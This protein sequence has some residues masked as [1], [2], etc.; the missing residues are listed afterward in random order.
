M[1]V[2]KKEMQR[3]SS[4]RQKNR[5]RRFKPEQSYKTVEGV[6]TTKALFSYAARPSHKRNEK[7]GDRFRMCDPSTNETK[8]NIREAICVS[9]VETAFPNYVS[10]VEN[11]PEQ[12]RFECGE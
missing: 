10:N 2:L 3:F 4:Q 1:N 12:P 8:R 7:G 5:L 9:D 11:I 6:L